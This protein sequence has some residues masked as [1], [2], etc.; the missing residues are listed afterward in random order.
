MNDIK[1]RWDRFLSPRDPVADVRDE[2]EPY[3]GASSE[4]HARDLASV[5]R[6]AMLILEARPDRQVVLDWQ[7]PR[8]PEAERLWLS[9]VQQSHRRLPGSGSS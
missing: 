2:I 3:V 6:T 7:D 5:C 9:I 8:S 4:R 1:S